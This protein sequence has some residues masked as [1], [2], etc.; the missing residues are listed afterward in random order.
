MPGPTPNVFAMRNKQTIRAPINPMDKSSVISIFPKRIEE[1]KCTIQP[2]VFV[3]EPGSV[4]HPSILLVG[5]SS[6]WREIDDEQ[7]LLEIPVSSIS[8]ANSVVIDYVNGILAYVPEVQSPGLFCLPGE[9][10]VPKLKSDPAGIAM[11]KKYEAMQKQWYLE[12]IKI[13][14]ILWARSNGNPLAVSSDARLACKELNIT[15]KPWLTDQATSELVKC[16]ACGALRN[17]AFP[18]CQTCKAIVDPV[19]AKEL[20]LTFAS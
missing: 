14:D 3:I 2:G 15:N 9:W 10:T 8:I 17:P 6:W 13:A 19:K 7:P 18:I 1:K 5:P 20:G 16:V 11:L 4:E 12:T